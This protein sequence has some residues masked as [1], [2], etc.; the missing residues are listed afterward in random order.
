MNK[1]KAISRVLKEL[2]LGEIL[3]HTVINDVSPKSRHG[4]P[5]DTKMRGIT[6][7]PGEELEY[8][9]RLRRMSASN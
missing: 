7:K 2:I 4:I 1:Q 3:L 9:I 6:S 5:T 8:C